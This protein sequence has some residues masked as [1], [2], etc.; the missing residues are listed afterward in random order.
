MTLCTLALSLYI[1]ELGTGRE[2]EREKRMTLELPKKEYIGDGAY[3]HYDGYSIWLTTS[4]GYRDTNKVCLEPPV[5]SSF[6]EYIE[7]LKVYI[8]RV[9]RQEGRL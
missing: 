5:L 8:E 4:D 3:A 1:L 9:K 2:N 7:R 6:L